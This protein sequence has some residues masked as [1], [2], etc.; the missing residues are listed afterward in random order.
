MRDIFAY[1]YSAGWILRGNNDDLFVFRQRQTVL[2]ECDWISVTLSGLNGL[3]LVGA[4]TELI[5]AF[6]N[7]LNS[8]ELLQDERWLEENNATWVS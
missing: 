6:R 1:L 5:V 8:M 2:P 7:M 4:S 3:R